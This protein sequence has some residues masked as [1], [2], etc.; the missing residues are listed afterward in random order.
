MNRYLARVASLLLLL[1][2]AVLLTA[3]DFGRG[4][5]EGLVVDTEGQAVPGLAVAVYALES[6]GDLGQGR[7]YQ[8]GTLLRE[9]S[10]GDDGAFSFALKRGSYIV[11][12]QRDGVGL[13]SRLVDVKWNRTVTVDFQLGASSRGAVYMAIMFSRGVSPWM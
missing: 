7:L 8:K 3:C 1:V 5:I 11:E 13:D 4:T 10:T 2:P 6:R 12:I 9:G